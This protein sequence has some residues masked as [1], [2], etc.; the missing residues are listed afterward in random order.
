MILVDTNVWSELLKPF[1]ND[2]VHDWVD[3]NGNQ[4]VLSSIVLGE[5]RLFV[6]KQEDGRRKNEL[7]DMLAAIRA[8]ADDRLLDFGEDD[9]NQY[10]KLMAEMRKSGTP[11]PQMDGLIAAQ[12]LANGLTVATR[13]IKDFQRTGVAL[14]NPWKE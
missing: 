9:A 6:E 12:A 13:N 7:H 4:L 14:V 5:L 8:R 3:R 10:G 11:L 2:V 1:R